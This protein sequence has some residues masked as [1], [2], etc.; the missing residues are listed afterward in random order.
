MA[1]KTAEEAYRIVSIHLAKNASKENTADKAMKKHGK[2][3][4]AKLGAPYSNVVDTIVDA[5]YN[6]DNY[7]GDGVPITVLY[8][9]LDEIL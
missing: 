9:H 4:I 8:K 7:A 1:A 3:L 6:I 2:D 5:F